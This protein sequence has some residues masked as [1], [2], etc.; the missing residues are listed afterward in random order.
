LAVAE[1]VVG[2]GLVVVISRLVLAAALAAMP[3]L[4]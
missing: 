3:F 1:A 4:I 2:A